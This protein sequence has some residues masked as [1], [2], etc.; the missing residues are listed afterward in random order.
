VRK[1][2]LVSLA[3][4]SIFSNGILAQKAKPAETKTPA[5]SAA[6]TARPAYAVP[7]VSKTLPNGLEVIVL[8]DPSVPIVTV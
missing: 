3:L 6:A 5:A 7:F 2:L 1:L 4:L 8:Q